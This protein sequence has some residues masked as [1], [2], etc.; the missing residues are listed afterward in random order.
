MVAD[1][2][3]KALLIP[4]FRYCL[5]ELGMHTKPNLSLWSS[6]VALDWNFVFV[7]KGVFFGHCSFPLLLTKVCLLTSKS[8]GQLSLCSSGLII[9]LFS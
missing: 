2:L 3:T 4:K 7:A 5:G 9:S 1:L 8:G 6:I